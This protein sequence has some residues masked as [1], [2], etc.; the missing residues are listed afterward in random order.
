LKKN[1]VATIAVSLPPSLYRALEMRASKAG[2]NLPEAAEV[3]LREGLMKDLK[4][5]VRRQVQAESTLMGYVDSVTT[6]LRSTG[7]WDE[8]VTAIVFEAIAEKQLSLYGEAIGGD[9]P[10]QTRG[11]EK[12][13]INKRIGARIKRLLNADVVLSKGT[14]VKGKASRKKPS[15]IT[16]YTLLR[17]RKSGRQG[18]RS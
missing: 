15:L 18:Q 3:V 7:D 16:S 13:R 12:T 4:P 10:F 14:R 17:P 2:I 6:G 11:A 8:H 9:D 5:S 1:E